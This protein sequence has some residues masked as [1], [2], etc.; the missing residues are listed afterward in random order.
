MLR[1]LAILLLLIT[2]D[3]APAQVTHLSGRMESGEAP[4][5]A[6]GPLIGL[7]ADSQLQTRQALGRVFA[8]RGALEDRFAEVA[9]RPPALDW[10]ARS[11][12]RWHLTQMSARRVE[13]IFYLGDGANNGCFDEFA[14]GLDAARADRDRIVAPNDQGV[15]AILDSFR[16][17]TGIPVYFV[18]GNHD[19]LGAGNTS[20]TR[21]RRDLCRGEAGSS[22]RPLTKFDVIHLVE[23]FNRANDRLGASWDY[24][25][26]F[27]ASGS[28]STEELCGSDEGQHRRWGCYLAARVNYRGAGP[29]VQL[30]LLDTNDFVGVTQS[31]V[32]GA[33][34]EGLRGAMSFGDPQGGVPSQ[35]RWFE[36]NAGNQVAMRVA[37]THY[38]LRSLRKYVPMIP[39]PVGIWSQQFI[40]LFTRPGT[41]RQP[42]QDAAYV[43]SA[44][45][46]ATD[47]NLRR[48]IFSIRCRI[49]Y[50][51]CR[52]AAR[53]SV[54]ELN[55]GSTTDNT[56]YS[57][58][59]RLVPSTTGGGGSIHYA[60]IPTSTAGCDLVHT[61]IEGRSFPHPVARNREGWKALGIDP[62][63]PR[64][65]R[66][67]SLADIRNVFAN[68]SEYAG[69]DE[70]RSR[71][72]ALRASAIEGGA[73]P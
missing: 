32:L 61:D 48:P 66:R 67:F 28:Q 17:D 34:F 24:A 18:I 16:S 38:D 15:L 51:N 7:V 56:N 50:P 33:E 60:R 5:G 12:L 55:I 4:A 64:N 62:R 6:Q 73:Y 19:F 59:A 10:S 49:I 71:C 41:P 43:I 26:S 57:T 11:L 9:I 27:A 30:L 20:I 36:Q 21:V 68:L 46:H 40:N 29:A 23:T 2:A 58:I 70:A 22:N 45:T 8:Y 72:I 63:S 25:S 54:N 69:A 1:Y 47:H 3:R 31:A 35:T 65:Y 13:A 39:R 42:A 14:G 52:G 44:H 37:L 53:F